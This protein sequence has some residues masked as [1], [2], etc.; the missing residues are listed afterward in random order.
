[1]YRLFEC[2]GL[3]IL[4]NSLIFGGQMTVETVLASLLTKEMRKRKGKD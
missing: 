4:T 1:M 3:D 2:H